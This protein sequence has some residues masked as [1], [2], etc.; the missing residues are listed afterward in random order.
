MEGIEGTYMLKYEP[1][2]D[3][4]QPMECVP[5]SF[6]GCWFSYNRSRNI[7]P[8]LAFFRKAVIIIQMFF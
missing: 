3:S 1:S 8:K 2:L 4:D 7:S 5:H 6:L